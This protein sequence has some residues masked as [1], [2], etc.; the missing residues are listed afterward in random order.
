MPIDRSKIYVT[1][2]SVRIELK[3]PLQQGIERMGLESFGDLMTMVA[4]HGEEMAQ[5]LAPVLQKHLAEK[6]DKPVAKRGKGKATLAAERA[7][8]NVDDAR[9][10]TVLE[11]LNLQG[12]TP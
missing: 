2:F 4:N 9:L 3:E 12:K 11:E 5:L 10:A 7:L 1:T 6:R 8:A